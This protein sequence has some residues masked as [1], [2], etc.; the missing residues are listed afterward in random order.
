MGDFG[1]HAEIM[2]DEQHAR[3]PPLLQFAHELEDLRLCCHVERRGRLIGDQQS[4]IEH[5]GG[6]DH[7]ALALTAGQ[8]VRIDIEQALGLGQP[9]RAHDIEYAQ[10]AF[11]RRQRGVDLEHLANLFA[12]RHHRIERRHGFLENHGHAR[13]A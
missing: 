4:W 2:G 1:H 11:G 12:N 10:P 6:R 5:Q 8:L 3:A 9:Y 7:D 13:A